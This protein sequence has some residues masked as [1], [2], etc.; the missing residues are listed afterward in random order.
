[1]KLKADPKVSGRRKLNFSNNFA[2][3]SSTAEWLCFLCDGG[4]G[5]LCNGQARRTN[6]ISDV[7]RFCHD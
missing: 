1:M 4:D 2:V 5:T 3:E 6:Y 7:C